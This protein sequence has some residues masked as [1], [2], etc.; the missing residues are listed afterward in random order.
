MKRNT[1]KTGNTKKSKVYE[2]ETVNNS[3]IQINEPETA[4]FNE[5]E[6]SKP[7]TRKVK[8]IIKIGF[9]DPANDKNIFVRY[10]IYK[11][12]AEKF[13][14]QKYFWPQISDIWHAAKTN[15]FLPETGFLASEV[16]P[17][18][19][20]FFEIFKKYKNQYIEIQDVETV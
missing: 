1:N 3:A 17:V 6:Q 12:I 15:E 5:S 4:K 7:E 10:D 9:E 18:L 16:K 14:R 2:P 13:L 19:S 8:T 11:F 20:V